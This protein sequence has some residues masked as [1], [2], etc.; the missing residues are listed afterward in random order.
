VRAINGF[1]LAV[2]LC[3]VIFASARS[4]AQST[5]ASAALDSGGAIH[6]SYSDGTEIVAP[7]LQDQVSFGHPRIARDKRTVGW[8]ANYPNCCTSYPIPMGLIIFRDGKVLRSISPGMPIWHWIFLADGEQVAVYTD[9]VHGDLNPNYE[10]C[11][12]G[13]GEAVGSWSPNSTKAQPE[14]VGLLLSDDSKGE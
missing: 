11:D 12:V 9:T 10:L 13:S 1:L 2:A 4:G 6:I 14:W 5:I 3:A 7:K 8:L